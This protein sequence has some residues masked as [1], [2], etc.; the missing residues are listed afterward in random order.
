MYK[1]II[2]IAL[3]LTSLT[4]VQA[5]DVGFLQFRADS[6]TSRPLDISVWYPTSQS[7]PYSLIAD[8]PAFVGTLVIRD[9][10]VKPGRFPVVILSHG[11]RGNWRNMNWLATRLAASGYLV[12]AVNHPGTTSRN[13]APQDAR[14][15]WQRPTDLSRTLDSLTQHPLWAEHIDQRDISVI[16]HSLGGWSTLLL[17]GA[18]VDREQLS[19]ECQRSPNPR[20][21]GVASEMGL[22]ARQD[23]E[24]PRHPL[25]DAR[26]KRAIL[27]DI[28]LAHSLSVSSLRQI[29]IPVLILAAGVDI[30]D[31]PQ[32]Q[33]SG[34]L[35]EHLPLRHTRYRVYQQAMHFSFLQLCKPDALTMLEQESKGDSIICRDAVGTQRAALHQTIYEDITAFLHQHRSPAPSL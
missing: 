27:L 22:F 16:G 9:A 30:G 35:S 17:T 3:L 25:R 8:N 2:V 11:Y 19:R 6:Q 7:T 1:C 5:N 28:G 14:Q 21:C 26:V 4:Q 24:P 34:F 31:L 23:D 13:H 33:E 10:S 18:E 20:T 15:W 12:T 29:D 32:S